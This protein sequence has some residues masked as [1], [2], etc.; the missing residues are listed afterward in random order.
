MKTLSSLD[1]HYLI[2]ELQILIDGKIDQ[3]YMP[4]KK[5]LLLQF[6]IPSKGKKLLR[7]IAGNCLYLTEKKESHEEPSDFCMFLRKHLGNARLREI[8]QKESERVVELV[9]EKKEGI[10]KLVI[11]FI[12]PGNILLLDKEDKIISAAEFHKFKDRA[13][14]SKMLYIYPKMPYNLFELKLKDLKEIL[15][16]SDKENIVKCLAVELGLGGIY[17]EELCKLANIDK[18]EKPADL[19]E[20]EIKSLSENL[21]IL[22]NKKIDNFSKTIENSI[23]DETPKTELRYEKQLKKLRDVIEKQESKLNEISSKIDENNKKAELIYQ[24]YNLIKDIITG[25]NKALEKHS[26]KEIEEKLKGHKIIK[27][28]NAKDKTVS[29]EL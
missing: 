26:W 3:I 11:E 7:I 16:K 4:D 18:N 12:P 20:K 21:F 24:N 13:V 2:N 1:I 15:K 14:M 22:V 29:I 10:E 19:D 17:S 28:I 8:N 5:E 27:E 23:T 25:I 6:H 9:F